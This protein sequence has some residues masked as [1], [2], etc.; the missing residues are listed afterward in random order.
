MFF[1]QNQVASNRDDTIIQ[2]KQPDDWNGIVDP[3]K[4]PY[5]WKR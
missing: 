4:G 2:R 1:K 5:G 3:P